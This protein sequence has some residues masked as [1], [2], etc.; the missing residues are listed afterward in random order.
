M[1]FGG[2]EGGYGMKGHPVK[3]L[4]CILALSPGCGG[5][6]SAGMDGG[7]AADAAGDVGADPPG[8]TVAE[9]AGDS[10]DEAG[11]ADGDPGAV[12]LDGVQGLDL[13][14]T[15]EAGT[16]DPGPTDPGQQDLSADGTREAIHAAE[17]CLGDVMKCAGK[18]APPYTCEAQPA[19]YLVVVDSEGRRF[20]RTDEPFLTVSAP[21][22]GESSCFTVMGDMTK[23]LRF[24]LPDGSITAPV[25]FEDDV[26]LVPCP[27]GVVQR[28]DDLL[29]YLPPFTGDISMP[30]CPG[31]VVPVWCTK[32][33]SICPQ[34]T[35]CVAVSGPFGTDGVCATGEDCDTCKFHTGCKAGDL[36]WRDDPTKGCVTA[37]IEPE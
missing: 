5:G 10:P 30:T 1:A 32:D 6:S 24:G 36:C 4:A 37:T 2:H 19:G 23:G 33:P 7:K 21:P 13:A 26:A 35:T 15:G 18:F 31:V 25:A 34:G 9:T 28:V 27:G 16:G 8:E 20:L 29:D 22:C 3:V 11:R 12:D 17:S 14:E